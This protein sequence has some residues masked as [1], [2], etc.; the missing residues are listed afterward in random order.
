MPFRDGVNLGVVEIAVGV[1]I[2]R[3]MH[4]AVGQNFLELGDRAGPSIE[5]GE[6]EIIDLAT[7]HLNIIHN[8]GAVQHLN[9]VAR[10]HVMGY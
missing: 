6:G 7:L 5:I 1:R 10:H 8:Q 2:E 3:V 4:C 9:A